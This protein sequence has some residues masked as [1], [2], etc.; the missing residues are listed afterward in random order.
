[1]AAA[2]TSS[3]SAPIL[4]WRSGLVR[5]GAGSALV[6]TRNPSR[7]RIGEYQDIASILHHVGLPAS[8][9]AY[10]FAELV[11]PLLSLDKTSNVT[12]IRLN[13]GPFGETI[14]NEYARRNRH[15]NHESHRQF[16]RVSAPKC[17]GSMA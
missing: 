6:V 16:S 11:F 10:R 7:P 5:G 15:P 1:M 3:R 12:P 14:G 9:E 13:T 2:A 4:G 17:R 8:G